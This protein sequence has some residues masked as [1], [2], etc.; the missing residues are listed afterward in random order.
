LVLQEKALEVTDFYQRT[1]DARG[2]W[3]GWAQSGRVSTSAQRAGRR[4]ADAARTTPLREL[5]G[6]RRAIPS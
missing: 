1:S 4:A 6:E 5:P 3:R 2:Y